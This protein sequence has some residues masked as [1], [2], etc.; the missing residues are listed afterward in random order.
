MAGSTK[1]LLR[2]CKRQGWKCHYCGRQMRWAA[3]DDAGTM[4]TFDHIIPRSRGGDR[5]AANGVAA[6]MRCN[7]ARG[8][9]NYERF[10]YL[11]EL[12]RKT[13]IAWQTPKFE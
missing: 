4:A 7:Q 9:L 1:I 10:K 13:D 5:S 2:L 11:V 8:T 12:N 3:G 6:C